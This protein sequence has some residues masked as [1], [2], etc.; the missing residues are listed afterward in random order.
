MTK[1]I[2][3]IYQK[4][5][6]DIITLKIR[7]GTR[8]KE[9][10]ISERFH[11]SRTPMRD[12]FKKLESDKLLVIYSQSGS[13]VTKIDLSGISDIMYLRTVT[14]TEVMKDVMGKMT[15]HDIEILRHLISSSADVLTSDGGERD[16]KVASSF[17][18]IDNDFHHYIFEKDGKAAVLDLLNSAFPYF[19]RYR[20]LTFYRDETEIHKLLNIHNQIVDC[21]EHQDLA[22]LDQVIQEH[23]YSGLNGIEKVKERHPD[24][25][26]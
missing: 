20:F 24:Y 25:F 13:Y 17:F 14:E 9:V 7:P 26:I 5:L 23:N 21:L 2:E 10:E 15:P 6:S 12:V 19:S 11:V 4:I 8:L 3:A 22:S 18:E 1:D 16:Q